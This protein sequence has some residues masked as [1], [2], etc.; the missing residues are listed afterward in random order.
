MDD[1]S[2]ESEHPKKRRRRHCNGQ[3]TSA[4]L[5][6][7][8]SLGGH[9]GFASEDLWIKLHALEADNH[10]MNFVELRQEKN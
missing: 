5:V 2:F 3:P 4:R 8:D 7:D 6:L 9:V 10:G 1:F